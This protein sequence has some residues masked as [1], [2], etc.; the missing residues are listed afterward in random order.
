MRGSIGGL[1]V[2]I[3]V[4]M[5]G[6]WPSAFTAD[7]PVE[8]SQESAV[9][10]A[11]EATQ[12]AEVIPETEE[13]I[14]L[15]LK[16]VDLV[17]LF[18]ILS[19]KTG[20][21][22]VPTKE[23]SGRV[24]IFLNNLTFADALDIILISQDLA[25]E[26]H[27]DILYIL[28]SAEYERLYGKKYNEKRGFVSVKLTYAEPGAIFDALSQIKSDI[29]KIV[30]DKGSG[31]ILLIDI[32][33]KLDLMQQTVRELDRPPR[34]E[35]FDLKY[36][37]SNELKDQLSDAVTE[38][39]GYL[40]VDERSNK[41]AVADLP[42][43]MKAIKRLV[44]AFDAEPRQVFIDASIVQITL[45][46]QSQR[47]G[48]WEKVF[49]QHKENVTLVGKFPISPAS[50]G[51]ITVGTATLDSLR[52]VLQLLQT[53]GDTKILSRPRIAAINNQ[54]AKILVGSREAY[55][56]QTQSQSATGPTVTAESVEFIDVGVKLNVVPTINT[57]GFVI[58]KIKPEVSEVRETVESALKS[59]IPIV[60][61]SEAETVV[62]VK[63]GTMIM[64]AGL[65]KEEQ[66]DDRKGTPR[67]SNLPIIGAVF[68][69]RDTLTKKTELIVFLTP[70][71]M[72][73]DAALAGTEPAYAIPTEVMPKDLREA[74]ISRIV[75]EKIQAIQQQAAGAPAAPP[76][77]AAIRSQPD[78]AAAVDVLDK[79]K[80]MQVQ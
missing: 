7:E 19:L 61:T 51:K 55:V 15:D 46:R 70:H 54:E 21:T 45:N 65:M 47:G 25:Y 8:E 60:Q 6:P 38:G 53:Y 12:A 26:R 49:G 33:E 13:K 68:G 24:N 76:S 3:V 41:V 56:T 11:V 28:T 27:G 73:G 66:R 17:E 79:M 72:T 59:K 43:K 18:R 75:S 77:P 42:E 4:T 78:K 63:D 29:G 44:Q 52:G 71:I 30:V 80:G 36:A 10:M 40:V 58:M 67:L 39:T 64:I 5:C 20:L 74:L 57:D 22:I 16:G 2:C 14:S 62:K 35:I 23:V 9:G 37:K 32:P 48:D 1:G 50:F 31:T 69:S 34:T